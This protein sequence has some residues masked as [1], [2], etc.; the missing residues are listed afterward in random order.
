MSN[1]D[2][3]LQITEC[4]MQIGPAGPRKA[5]AAGWWLLAVGLSVLPVFPSSRLS[6]QDLENGK[7]LYDKWCSGC[8]GMTGAGDGD[9]A[10]YMLP[11]PRD[12]TP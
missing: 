6:A 5:G 7:I 2:L 3:I 8:H 12:F 4:R 11:R 10:H 9:A 1:G